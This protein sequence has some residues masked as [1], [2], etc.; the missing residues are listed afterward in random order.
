MRSVHTALCCVPG[1]LT[2]PLCGKISQNCHLVHGPINLALGGGNTSMAHVVAIEGFSR[3]L[4][5]G[6]DFLYH[7]LRAKIDVALN[8]KP[9]RLFQVDRGGT[10]FRESHIEVSEN[11]MHE[12][13]ILRGCLAAGPPLPIRRAHPSSWSHGY[14]SRRKQQKRNRQPIEALHVR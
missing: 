10:R 1:V 9:P 4:Q 3:G 13:E 14:C 7:F 5:L 12:H 2:T 6:N 11:D 8:T